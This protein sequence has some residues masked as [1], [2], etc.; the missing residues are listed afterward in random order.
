MSSNAKK[1]T[2][3]LCY[4]AIFVWPWNFYVWT[5][6]KQYTNEHTQTRAGFDWSCEHAMFSSEL[7]VIFCWFSCRYFARYSLKTS[8]NA[9]LEAE[10]IWGCVQIWSGISDAKEIRDFNKTSQQLA[11]KCFSASARENRASYNTARPICNTFLT[12]FDCQPRA[13][14]RQVLASFN[15]CST[16]IWLELRTCR[17][18][19]G[20]SDCSSFSR[21]LLGNFVVVCK[22]FTLVTFAELKRARSMHWHVDAVCFTS[23]IKALDSISIGH[24][25]IEKRTKM[26]KM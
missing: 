19:H 6:R 3:L 22:L 7:K 14:G 11:V 12:T 23:S 18:W 4:R 25:K 20:C 5:E 16:V 15:T 9:R 21:S 8:R 26:G 24:C 13:R 2:V 10:Q 1:R 17:W